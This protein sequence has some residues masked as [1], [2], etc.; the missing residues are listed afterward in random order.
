MLPAVTSPAASN[1]TEVPAAAG[2][3][4]PAPTPCI[5]CA[6]LIPSACSPSLRSLFHLAAPRDG[7]ATPVS[8]YLHSGDQV[9]AGVFPLARLYPAGTEW[10]FYRSALYG[11][12]RCCWG[13][14]GIVPA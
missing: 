8:A 14:H 5:R 2:E 12:V 11:L 6:I 4:D 7:G 13:R 1:P 10:F 3:L 9:R